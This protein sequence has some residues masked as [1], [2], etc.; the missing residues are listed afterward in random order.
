MWRGALACCCL[1][2]LIGF[3]AQAGKDEI[4]VVVVVFPFHLIQSLKQRDTFLNERHTKKNSDC[5]LAVN[6]KKNKQDKQSKDSVH[7]S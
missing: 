5:Y 6:F 7:I 4:N 1:L 3:P 2:M